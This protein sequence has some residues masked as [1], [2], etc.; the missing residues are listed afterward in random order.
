MINEKQINF[1]IPLF[2]KNTNAKYCFLSECQDIFIQSSKLQIKQIECDETFINEE[3]YNFKSMIY[4]NISSENMISGKMYDAI[5]TSISGYLIKQSYSKLNDK[6][7]FYI[8]TNKKPD[9]TIF[10]EED[11]IQLQDIGNGSTFF[12]KLMYYIDKEELFVM[13]LTDI[14]NLRLVEREINNYRRINHP[15]IIVNFILK[16]FI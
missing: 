3:I 2:S 14:D 8:Q 13:K 9:E 5:L 12:V 4:T 6:Y 16:A 15:L 7:D 1:L 11:F 10:N